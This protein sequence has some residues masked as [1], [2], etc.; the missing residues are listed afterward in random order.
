MTI[1]LNKAVTR[2]LSVLAIAVAGIALT[3]CSAVNDA[4]E[5]VTGNETSGGT[6]VSGTGDQ[7]NV[8]TIKVGDCLNDGAVSGEVSEVPTID[9]AQPHDSEA[10]ASV[11]VAEGDYPGEDAIFAEADASCASTFETYVGLPYA[12]S[13]FEISYYFPTEATWADGD[14]EIL[15]V[16]YDPA[17]PI[18][19]SIQGVA[20]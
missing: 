1:S 6:E 15:C 9:C 12:D 19:G 18:T 5:S 8:F 16:A 10:Y 13:K 14:R 3:G 2:G 17:G 20:L 4:I 11:M 7:T